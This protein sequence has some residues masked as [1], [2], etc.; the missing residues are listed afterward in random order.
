[1]ATANELIHAA[2]RD[3]GVIQS[4]EVMSHDEV[5][6]GLTALQ[7]MLDGWSNEHLTLYHVTTESFP[8]TIGQAVYTYGPGG[9][10]DDDRPQELLSCYLRDSAGTDFMVEVIYRE[11]YNVIPN[12]GSGG[13][14]RFVYWVK[15]FPL[16]DIK[17]DQSPSQSYTAYFDVLHALDTPSAITTEVNF[18]KGYNRAIRKNLAIEM[19]PEYGKAIPQEVAAIADRALYTLKRQNL[20]VPVLL[21]EH[22]RGEVYN[23]YSDR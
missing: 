11:R 20:R 3:L 8:L 16:S 9:D 23:I 14:P 19:A 2:A 1:M 5:Q 12:K 4:G 10:F 22:T 18:P 17:F 13:L 6:D 21:T 7:D 15:D